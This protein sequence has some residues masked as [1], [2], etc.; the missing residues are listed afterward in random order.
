MVPVLQG[1]LGDAEITVIT[2][3]VGRWI[4]SDSFR[5]PPQVMPDDVASLMGQVLPAPFQCVHIAL[6]AASV[7]VDAMDLG[8][9]RRAHGY[10]MP[11]DYA[12]PRLD[13]QLAAIGI[14]AAQITAVVVTHAHDDH[15]LLVTV[16]EN[17]RR[18]PLFPNAEIIAHHADWTV[19]GQQ[20]ILAAQPEAARDPDAPERYMGEI[21]RRGRLRLITETTEIAP[22]IQVTPTPGET[23]GHSVARV[24]SQEKTL[25]CLGDLFHHPSEIS[26]PEWG[27]LWAEPQQNLRSRQRLC[28]A[29]LAEGARLISSHI[30]GVGRLARSGDHVRWEAA[31]LA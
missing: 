26:H 28:A 21:I 22:G 16:E 19:A 23:P 17:G 18:E 5:A 12:V 25:Y 24:Q 1:A 20:A 2:T 31:D 15:Y 6:G 4:M 10:R 11:P 7:L 27:P 3:G 8:M 13:A 29:A 9:Y 14:A 30:P